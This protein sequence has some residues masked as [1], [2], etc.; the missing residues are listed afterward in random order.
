MG[1]V[2]YD[3]VY[4]SYRVS[5]LK[6]LMFTFGTSQP[7]GFRLL[8]CA[9][10]VGLCLKFVKPCYQN[11]PIDSRAIRFSSTIETYSKS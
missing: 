6:Q 3:I 2:Q 4:N 5:H 11:V 1:Y 9:M 10:K 7:L 8:F